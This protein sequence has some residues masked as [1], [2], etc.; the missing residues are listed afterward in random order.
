M[1]LR[2]L[3]LAMFGLL[4]LGVAACSDTAK[5]QIKVDPTDKQSSPVDIGGVLFGEAAWPDLSGSAGVGTTPI[6]IP[7]CHLT[8]LNRVDV[9]SKEDGT[10]DWLGVEVPAKGKIPDKD[11]Y[12]H[13]REFKLGDG[14]QIEEKLYRRLQPGERV[15][16]G[17]IIAI[18][19]DSRALLDCEIAASNIE[20][21]KLEQTA[22]KEGIK[23]YKKYV[24]IEK[25]VGTEQ[26][27]AAALANE[28]RAIAEEASKA[29]TVQRTVG[30]DKKANEKLDNHLIRAPITG[31]I[32]QFLK[33]EGEGVRVSEP[34]LQL[35]NTDR[36]GVQG[37][38]EVQFIARV[39]P[40]SDIF[41]EPAI[42]DPPISS[43]SPHTSNRPITA[44]AGGIRKGKQVVVS[45][46][47]DG[48][49]HLWDLQTVHASWRH[50]AAVRALA[51][52]RPGVAKPLVLT[53]CDDGKARLFLLEGDDST[54]TVTLE[55]HHEGGV[56]AVAFTP[57]GTRCV[58]ADDRGDLFLFDTANGKLV[59]KFPHEHNSSVTSLT[60]T[61]QCRLVSAGRDQVAHLWKLGAKSA[62]VDKTFD[63]RSGEVANLGVSDDGGQM[64]LDLDKNR[65]RV[66]DLAKQRSRGT[67][68]QGSDGKFAAFA[69]FSPVIGKQGARVI[70]TT[71]GS[72]GVLQ[73][74]R[75]TDDAG[76]G[77]ELRKLVC[78]GYATAT[79]AAIS[80]VAADGFLIAGTRRG[81]VLLWSMPTENELTN[82]HKA[83]LTS[84]DTNLES[85]GRTVRVH[86]EFENPA[87]SKARLR[88]GT[89][90]TMVIPRQ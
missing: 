51:V 67:L 65:L 38:L 1:P 88:P 3:R 25:K 54:P 14:K 10:I 28:A 69:L 60:V 29:W 12:L 23:Y 41:L 44:V 68:E 79:C 83:R 24:E 37:N 80:P 86:A 70:L 85:S 35:Q 15:V 58:T 20:S 32:V 22:A 17:Q 7:L 45:A 56:Q 84:V 33:H 71:S 89:T 34:V 52:T 81:D 4:V 46:S 5:P 82:R 62:A 40:G 64:I 43:E 31:E 59:Y 13:K 39:Q 30:E 78:T 16:K 57:D 50:T 9:P 72:D 55:G 11:L 53:G 63:H 6:R 61:P 42:L 18:M 27:I 73:V 19:N 87:D 26:Q 36:L 48:S 74:W 75:W 49:V 21:A 76:R 77:T 90:A 47:E 8:V 66:I 2:C